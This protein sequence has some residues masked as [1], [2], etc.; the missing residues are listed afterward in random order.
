MR[1]LDSSVNMRKTTATVDKDRGKEFQKRQLTSPKNIRKR[2]SLSGISD[3]NIA[4]ASGV[5]KTKS[6][7]DG[8]YEEEISK[9]NLK[10]KRTPRKEVEYKS[11]FGLLVFN[12]PLLE[13]LLKFHTMFYEGV[14]DSYDPIKKKHKVLYADGDEEI[15]NL[16]RERWELIGGAILPDEEPKTDIPNANLIDK[17]RATS[18]SKRKA[19]KSAGAVTQDEPI[20][21]DK[22]MDDTSRPNSGAEGDGKGSTGKLKIGVRGLESTASRKL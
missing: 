10:R 22:A 7:R 3:V 20:V 9:T 13:D 1:K 6:S 5:K 14:L 2:S 4:E 17:S 12:H 8:S 11:I 16:R 15:L 19:R 18:I 21:A